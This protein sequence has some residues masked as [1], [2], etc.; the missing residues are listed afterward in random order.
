MKPVR[1]TGL[2][3]S[4][5]SI[6]FGRNCL[7]L[8]LGLAFTGLL[9][10]TCLGEDGAVQVRGSNTLRG[11]FYDN[12]GS[13]DVSPFPSERDHWYNE[14]SLDVVRRASP[15]DTMRAQFA[16]LYNDSDYRSEFREFVLERGNVLWEKGDWGVPFRVEAGDFLSSVSYRTQFRTLK[17]V[18]LELQPETDLLG[19]DHSLLMFL[20]ADQPSWRRFHGREDW[21]TGASWLVER[22]WLG[23]VSLNEVVNSFEAT[24]GDGGD[25]REQNILSLA[26]E[27]KIQ[28]WGELLTLEAEAA[29]FHGEPNMGE[30]T[31]NEDDNAYLLQAS[32]DSSTPLTARLRYE[33][34]GPNFQPRGAVATPNRKAFEA[35]AGWRFDSGLSLRTRYQHYVDGFQDPNGTDTDVVGFTLAGPILAPWVE[36]LTSNTSGF[37]RSTENQDGTTDTETANLQLSVSKP[38]IG[39]WNLTPSTFLQ[40]DEDHTADGQ[41]TRTIQGGVAL[42]HAVDFLG[43]EGAGS[44]GFVA[45]RLRG[46]DTDGDEYLPTAALH[47]ARGP[48][49]LGADLGFQSQQRRIRDAVD[50]DTYTCAANYSYN[51]GHHTLGAEVRYEVRQHS[52]GDDS[53]AFMAALYWT[54]DFD[55][56]LKPP[57]RAPRPEVR[58]VSQPAAPK[59]PDIKALLDIVPGMSLDEALRAAESW[60][61]RKPTRRPT[62]VVFDTWL[63]SDVQ[64]RQRVALVY[65]KK[66]VV[67]KAALIIDI[68]DVGEPE[69]VRQLFEKVRSKLVHTFGRPV[70]F[71][72]EGEFSPALPADVNMGRLIRINEWETP[73]GVLRF[74][75]PRRLDRRVRMEI[76]HARRFPALR[77]TLWSVR[78]VK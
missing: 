30:S 31:G 62:S 68:A 25:R 1:S 24:D 60:G 74:G 27:R 45:R 29:R 71:Y 57:R 54:Y 73:A 75:I 48:H 19:G 36:N 13:N 17:G 23:S 41:T 43:W 70:V 55:F 49:A 40:R 58:L 50:S 5:T 18:Q 32:W 72:E 38:V 66:K 39:G 78:E 52:P 44:M 10:A 51:W 14:L 46:A 47:V 4:A 63:M 11:E 59:R 2:V 6:R 9:G 3:P 35:H 37:I 64:Q 26:L 15:Y 56:Q 8:A 67:T 33:R 28:L 21:S 7:A 53:K 42:D 69:T 22:S 34:N 65:D 16:G 12:E 77:Q 20:G 76:Q 61:L